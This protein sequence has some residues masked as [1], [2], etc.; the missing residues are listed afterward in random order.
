MEET[1]RMRTRA[2]LSSDN[3]VKCSLTEP[4]THRCALDGRMLSEIEQV[5]VLSSDSLKKKLQ[6]TLEFIV[7]NKKANFD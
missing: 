6:D 3:K 2:G 5:F 4:W 1:G 7:L